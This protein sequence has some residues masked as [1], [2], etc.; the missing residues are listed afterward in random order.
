MYYVRGWFDGML[1]HYEQTIQ[2]IY[3]LHI[4]EGQ[5]YSQANA[6]YPFRGYWGCLRALWVRWIRG[7]ELCSNS[8]KK[9]AMMEEP[10]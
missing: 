7:V 2:T 9:N 1:Q 10:Y 5:D 3:L 6:V 4:I 8:Y